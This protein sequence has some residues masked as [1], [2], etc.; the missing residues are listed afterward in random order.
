[1]ILILKELSKKPDLY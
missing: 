1:L